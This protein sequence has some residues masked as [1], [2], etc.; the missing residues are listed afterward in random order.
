MAYKTAIEPE[1]GAEYVEGRV[2]VTYKDWNKKSDADADAVARAS[3]SESKVITQI[4]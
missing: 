3:R 4:P 1:T 2:V